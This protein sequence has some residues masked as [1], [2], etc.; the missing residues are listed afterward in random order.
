MPDAARRPFQFLADARAPMPAGQLAERAR[1]AEEAGFHA[2]V[3]PDHL[4]DQMSP[5]PAM[6]VIAASTGRLRIGAFVFNNDL[7]HPAV[8]A[9]D[10]ATLDVL[11]GGRLDVAIGAGWNQAEY[12]AIGLALEPGPVRVHRLE[13]A[14]A[15]LKGCFGEGPFSFEGSHYRITDYD[16]GPRP[17]QRPHPPFMIGGGGRRILSLAAHEAQIVGLAPTA[18]GNLPRFRRD[19]TRQQVAWVR[20]AAGD[21]FGELTLNVYASFHPLTVTDDARGEARR[22]VDALRERAGVDLTEDEV[23]ASPHLWI[24]SVDALVEKI[25]GLR[26]ELGITSFMLGDPDE[27]LPIVER[28]AGS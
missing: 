26:E 28:L 9:Q 4:I 7:R 20:E 19:T 14:V 22:V 12:D 16:A 2:L 10:L 23:L 11:S 13:E 5:A 6:A 27:M 17:V 21:R 25:Q 15:V 24:G 3:I 1:R 18:A 8:L